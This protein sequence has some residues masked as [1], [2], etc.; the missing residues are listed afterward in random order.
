MHQCKKRP[1]WYQHCIFDIKLGKLREKNLNWW[2]NIAIF[3]RTILH[4]RSIDDK[5]YPW[6]SPIFAISALLKRW[7][8][9][10]A[11]KSNKWC[12]KA[13][14]CSLSCS[15]ITSLN[16]YFDDQ[17]SITFILPNVKSTPCHVG[18]TTEINV[19]LMNCQ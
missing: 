1:L 14:A 6:L 16:K 9:W 10:I 2:W 19:N 12:L 5:T 4:V 13:S 3:S 8:W 18:L 17:I 7:I 11:N 15:L